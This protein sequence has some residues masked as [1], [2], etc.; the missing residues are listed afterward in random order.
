MKD[1]NVVILALTAKLIGVRRKV[2]TAS[3]INDDLDVDRERI[4]ISKVILDCDELD[5]IRTHTA[6][7][8]DYVRSRAV[9]C[10]WV[11]DGMYLVHVHA[12]SSVHDDL[13]AMTQGVGYA[14]YCKCKPLNQLIQ[15]FAEKYTERVEEEK[16]RLGELFNPLDYPDP[17]EISEMGVTWRF[18]SFGPAEELQQVS[19]QLF[20]EERRKAE[21]Q[22]AEALDQARALLRA[23]MKALVDHMVDR[24]KVE[25][26]Q[27]PKIFRNSLVHNMDEWLQNFSLRNIANDAQLQELVTRARQIMMHVPSADA[28][29]ND[30]AL[31]SNVAQQM[32]EIKNTL[33]GLVLE[34]PSR[35]IVLD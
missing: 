29:R 33:D 2:H 21:I 28:L 26:G 5:A 3:V 19:A 4:K 15:S 27:K 20:E 9:P 18:I 23:E 8:R 32:T 30:E 25:P 17:E 13:V 11:K 16:L 34:Q 22:W 35:V 14:G 6:H 31:R 10:E 12:A 24:L 7:I 1:K